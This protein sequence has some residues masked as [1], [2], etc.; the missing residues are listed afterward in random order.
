MESPERLVL[1]DQIGDGDGFGNRVFGKLAIPL[2][3]DLVP[4]EALIELFENNPHHNARA[5]ERGLTAADFR[6][7][8]DVPSEFHPVALSIC[9]RFH[10]DA[11]TM[12][13]SD[14]A[15][16]RLILA[17]KRSRFSLDLADRRPRG[18]LAKASE[19]LH[20]TRFYSPRPCVL[21]SRPPKTSPT[22][23]NGRT[24]PLSRRSMN[25]WT[26]WSKTYDFPADCPLQT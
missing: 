15:S 25:R 3:H 9:L 23:K 22:R 21:A 8:H 12:R 10:A 26:R 13:L 24:T 14:C 20:P 16:K 1:H 7:R 18:P 4:G 17:V 6:I 2:E 11:P 5:L 19:R